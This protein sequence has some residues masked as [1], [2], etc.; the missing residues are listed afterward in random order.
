MWKIEQQGQEITETMREALEDPQVTQ[1]LKIIKS[2]IPEID[3]TDI[4]D[5]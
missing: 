4:K 5:V 2:R 3:L 1:K